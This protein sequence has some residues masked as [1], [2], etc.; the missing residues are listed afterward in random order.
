MMADFLYLPCLSLIAI[1]LWLS[2]G[3]LLLLGDGL[4]LGFWVMVSE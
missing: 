1:A 2:S 4:G 3:R